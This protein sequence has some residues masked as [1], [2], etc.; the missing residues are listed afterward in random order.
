MFDI[1]YNPLPNFLEIKQSDVHG[2]GLFTKKDLPNDYVLGISHIRDERFENGF[3]RTPLGGF[4]N[5]TTVNPNIEP[6][7]IGDMIIIKTIKK[8]LAGEELKATYTLYNPEK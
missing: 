5:H 8:I 3:I 6:V 4:F 2:L 1:Y 7:H